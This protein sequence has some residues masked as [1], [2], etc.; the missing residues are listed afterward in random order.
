MK[1]SSG[2]TNPGGEKT[3]AMGCNYYAFVYINYR[4][5]QSHLTL[6]RGDDSEAT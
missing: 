3:H 6:I 1:S 2:F 4:W 5:R